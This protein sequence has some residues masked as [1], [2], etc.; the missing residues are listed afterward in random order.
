MSK[1]TLEQPTTEA[2]AGQPKITP[3]SRDLPSVE[4]FATQLP[5]IIR[6]GQ[7]KII[8]ITG[9]VYDQKFQGNITLMPNPVATGC[10]LFGNNAFNGIYK[11]VSFPV[12]PNSISLPLTV[13]G[14]TTG[15]LGKRVCTLSYDAEV[16]VG[17]VSFSVGKGNPVTIEF[18]LKKKLL[19]GEP[20]I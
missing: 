8:N 16:P 17:A 5:I 9:A 19:P 13:T 14:P 4:I 18:M 1:A 6:Q 3:A 20:D 15:A 10:K 11:N 12:G 2:I 7:T